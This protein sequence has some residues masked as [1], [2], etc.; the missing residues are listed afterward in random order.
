MASSTWR[1]TPTSRRPHT[2]A[3]CPGNDRMRSSFIAS[4][5]RAASEA[6]MPSPS[7]RPIA[8]VK[9]THFARR[10]L[11]PLRAPRA[12]GIYWRRGC[13]TPSV[14]SGPSSRRIPYTAVATQRLSGRARAA[15]FMYR[16]ARAHPLPVGAR[17]VPAA[18]G[19]PRL[20]D[21]AVARARDGH[22][23]QHPA[24]HGLARRPVAA[25]AR[26]SPSTSSRRCRTSPMRISEF[27]SKVSIG[28]LGGGGPHLHARDL[29]LALQLR[30]EDLQRHLARRAAP[31][32]SSASSSPSTRW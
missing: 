24:R 26:S 9:K 29:L 20:P 17:Q 27:S 7:P 16:L 21:G 10:P 23:L 11:A 22:R 12:L 6:S 2:S 28:A 18:G 1:K 19:R 15:I 5:V 30:R 3:Y 4:N 13:A 31:H 8:P 25:L 32:A 14:R